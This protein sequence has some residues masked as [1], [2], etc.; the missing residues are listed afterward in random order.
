M[1]EQK[2]KEAQTQKQKQTNPLEKTGQK[3]RMKHGR[4]RIAPKN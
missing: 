3:H 2:S 1:K 4:A